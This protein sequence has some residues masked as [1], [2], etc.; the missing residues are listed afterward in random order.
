MTIKVREVKNEL[1]EEMFKQ[2]QPCSDCPFRKEGGVR[3]G[4]QAAAEYAL[5]FC[6]KKAV[7]F[8]C[9]QTVPKDDP[10][11]DWSGWREGQTLCAGGL[12]FAEKLGVRNNIVRHGMAQ[13][14]YDPTKR[15]DTGM[16]FDSI[17]EM[18]LAHETGMIQIAL[19]KTSE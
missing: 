4:A 11:D 15:I 8:P 16:V 5:Y 12:A 19:D 17:A 2:K 18:M 1:S 6:G 10:R 14:W 13:G 7:T 9:H 3:H